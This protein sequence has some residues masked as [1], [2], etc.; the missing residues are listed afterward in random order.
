MSLFSVVFLVV[1]LYSL[2][3]IG[4]FVDARYSKKL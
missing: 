2:M 4:F 3:A 1:G